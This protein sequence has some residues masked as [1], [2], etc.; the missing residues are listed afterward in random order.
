MSLMSWREADNKYN[1][2][3]GYYNQLYAIRAALVSISGTLEASS[4]MF[5]ESEK[6]MTYC[7]E[8]VASANIVLKGFDSYTTL[9]S[10]NLGII[11]KVTSDLDNY[12]VDLDKAV[13]ACE[14]DMDIVHAYML[15][16]DD[17][18]TR[19]DR[20]DNRGQEPPESEFPPYDKEIFTG[21]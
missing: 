7:N 16:L 2:Q 12:L 6:D 9:L 8:T 17:Y 5:E 4:F 11:S 20:Y 15:Y 1:E 3:L 18:K 14:S 13:D 10:D 19:M 21:F